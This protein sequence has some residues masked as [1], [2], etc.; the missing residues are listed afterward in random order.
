MKKS[1][2]LIPALALVLASC[3]GQKGSQNQESEA[4]NAEEQTVETPIV[5]DPNLKKVNW[6][7]PLYALDENGDTIRKWIYNDKGQL[8]E[9]VDK[10]M[11]ETIHYTYDAKGNKVSSDMINGETWT[12]DEQGRMATYQDGFEESSYWQYEYEGN[13]RK[14]T[15]SSAYG[16]DLYYKYYYLDKDMKYDT[17]NLM[18]RESFDNEWELKTV[19]KYTTI[20][21]KK[22][23]SEET[24]YYQKDGAI[25]M[26]NKTEYEYNNIGAITKRTFTNK[27]GEVD[28][29]EIE[30][31]DNWKKQGLTKTY[32]SW[33]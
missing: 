27:A 28:I 13:I 4:Q 12:Y 30:T 22:Y 14:A 1:F 33:E 32:Y 24:E 2:Y 3:G 15:E 18:I 16:F 5:D 11:D 19:K 6:D 9:S 20:L 26:E 31:Q 21:G 10:S 29:T 8:I 25:S 7:K 23:L 17:L